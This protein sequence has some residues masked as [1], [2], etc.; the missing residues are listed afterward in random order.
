MVKK[1]DSIEAAIDDMF[2]LV[3]HLRS[4]S[5]GAGRQKAWLGLELTMPQLKALLSTLRAGR[6]TS[7]ELADALGV[8]ASA[9][10]PVVDRLVE[11]KLVRREHDDADRRVSWIVPTAQAH[12]L[13]ERLMTVGRTTIKDLLDDL[14]DDALAAAA[15]G[16][17]VLAAAARRKQQTPQEQP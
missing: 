10:T 12:A 14:D 11:H 1:T 7:R 6:A 9:I 5:V 16:L 2:V 15:A 13:Q 17:A 8:T 4:A 3:Q